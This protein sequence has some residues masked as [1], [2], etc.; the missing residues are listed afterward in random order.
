MY[1]TQSSNETLSAPEEPEP[2]KEPEPIT[3]SAPIKGTEPATQSEPIPVRTATPAEAKYALLIAA[4]M[5]ASAL[6]RGT[7]IAHRSPESI[8]QKMDSGHAVIAVTAKGT[9]AGF[10]YIESW[11]EG[12][13]VSNSGMIVSPS[14]RGNGVAS[15]I[16][17]HIFRLSRQLYPAANIFSITTGLAIMKLNSNLGFMPVTYSEITKDEK[18]WDKCRHCVNFDILQSKQYKN[19]LCT[20]ML[21]QVPEDASTDKRATEASAFPIDNPQPA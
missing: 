21:Y 19:C 16:K 7:G 18:F 5:K 10:S 17:Q 14:F 3:E 2:V 1:T 6:A 8:I 4:E 13:F 12:A 15:A 20:A 9:W 11:Q